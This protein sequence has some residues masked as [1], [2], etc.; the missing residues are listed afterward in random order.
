MEAAGECFHLRT[1]PLEP[2]RGAARTSDQHQVDVGTQWQ[3]S[4]SLAQ[5]PLRSVALDRAAHTPGGD[6]G[7]AGAGSTLRRV[8][9]A[10]RPE[11]GVRD[12][13]S[14]GALLSAA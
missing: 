8:R 1:H 2:R 12:R 9:T 3:W 7:D 14:A 13:E 10:A 4:D 5:Q 11:R 6:D